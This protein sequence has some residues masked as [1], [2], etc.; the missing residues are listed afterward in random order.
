MHCFHTIVTLSHAY[1]NLNNM[2]LY[3]LYVIHYGA[4]SAILQNFSYIATMLTLKGMICP[5][6]K[7]DPFFTHN[8]FGD[9]RWERIPPSV[10]ILGVNSSNLQGTT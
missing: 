9:S 3:F 8:L 10:I 7:F 6:V 2:D 5:K 4:P 1:A